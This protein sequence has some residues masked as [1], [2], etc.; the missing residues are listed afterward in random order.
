MKELGLK[1]YRFSIAWPRVLPRGVGRVNAK[2][3]D[4]YH[5]LVDALL[6]ADIQPMITLFHWDYPQSLWDRGGLLTRDSA[7]WFGEYAGKVFRALG[8]RVKL[9]LTLNEPEVFTDCG[10]RNPF[11]R[12]YCRIGSGFWI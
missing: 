1:A 6:A 9:W 12:R 3:M 7:K 5:Q 11:I 2:G 8:D 4:F 10:F